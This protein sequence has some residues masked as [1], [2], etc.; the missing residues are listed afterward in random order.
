MEV[1]EREERIAYIKE[2]MKEDLR[3]ARKYDLL[4][5]MVE[6]RKLRAELE[7]LEADDDD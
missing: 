5:P 7:T 1:K 2:R 4:V 3:L 6:Y